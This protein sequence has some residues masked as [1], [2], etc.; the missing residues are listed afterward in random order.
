V[1]AVPEPRLEVSDALGRRVILIDKPTFTIGR[2]SANDL[3]LTG[4]DVSRDHAEIV[5]IDGRHALRDRGS[6]SGTTVNG[7][8]VTERPLAHGDRIRVGRGAGADMVF[9]IGDGPAPELSLSGSSGGGAAA[10]FR[11]LSSLLNALRALGTSRVLDEVL[12]LVMDAA[13][14]A[15]GAERG[16]IM[17]ANHGGELELKLARLHGQV[18]LA[19]SR[20]DTS[21]KIPEQVFATAQPLIVGDLLDEQM[22]QAHGGTI[23]LGIRHVMCVPLRVVQYVESPRTGKDARPIGVLYLD[24]REKGSLLSDTARIS[25]ETLAAEASVAIENARLYREASEKAR[26]D[27][28][29]RVAGEIQQS[30]LP[31]ARKRVGFGEAV[32]ASI[33][34]RAIGG[35]FYE[36]LDL[37]D[38]RFGFA[39]GDVSGKGPPAAL[40]TAV[41]QGLFA[42][43]IF[44]PVDPAE[45]LNRINKALLARGVEGRFATIFFAILGADG[46]LTYCNAGHNA[47]MLLSAGGVRRLEVGGMVVG[48][49]PFA[50]YEQ[51]TLQLAPGDSLMVFSDGVSEALNVGGDEFGDPRIE[52]TIVAR[53]GEEPTVVLQALLAAVKTFAHGA[54][55]NDDVTAMVVKFTG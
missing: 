33:A 45:M 31:Q 22:A 14:D 50:T 8:P 52:E 12:V 17:L 49:F 3:A 54:A 38:G 55:Q 51:E 25:L 34:C 32:G 41:L 43:Q 40:L 4:T 53:R 19:G 24:S 42:G 36:Y 7:V 10:G 16:F 47:P 37:P 48:L 26:L 23:A 46:Q 9:L 11:Q 13:I 39:L 2:R 29:L 18:S 27:E 30:L 28:E 6:R 44:A 1:S 5:L 15:T 35:D 21:R 20:F